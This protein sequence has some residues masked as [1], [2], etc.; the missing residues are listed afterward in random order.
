MRARLLAL[1]AVVLAGCGPRLPDSLAYTGMPSEVP[2]GC[3]RRAARNRLRGGLDDNQ[4][5]NP[6]GTQSVGRS[7][8]RY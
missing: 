5:E 4:R 3:A 7:Q 1:C 8:A 6:R 2:G